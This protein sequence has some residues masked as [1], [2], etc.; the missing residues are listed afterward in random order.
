MW[1]GPWTQS[2]GRWTDPLNGRTRA[3]AHALRIGGIAPTWRPAGEVGHGPLTALN[4]IC[5]AHG[6]A[7]EAMHKVTIE[8]FFVRLEPEVLTEEDEGED[9]NDAPLRGHEP[10]DRAWR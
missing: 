4:G 9:M 8:F 5:E 3:R 6:E 1:R 7:L 10:G 2:R